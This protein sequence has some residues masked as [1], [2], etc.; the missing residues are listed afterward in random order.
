MSW[1]QAA[2]EGNI[3]ALNATINACNNDVGTL[4]EAHTGLTPLHYAAKCGRLD[5]V[6]FLLDKHLALNATDRFGRTPLYMG[7]LHQQPDTVGFLLQKKANPNICCQ[8][9]TTALS[10]AAEYGDKKM[11]SLLLDAGA[12]WNTKNVDGESPKELAARNGHGMPWERHEAAQ[13][14]RLVD[15]A[16][17]GD[18]EDMKR[19]IQL[20]VE[21]AD[22]PPKSM[23]ALEAACENGRIDVVR[24][25]LFDPSVSRA[26]ASARI[27]SMGRLA[28]HEA[29]K[30]GYDEVVDLLLGTGLSSDYRDPDNMTPLHRA[31]A[32][33]HEGVAEVLLKFHAD[34]NAKGVND[35]SPLHQAAMQG[36]AEMVQF[37]LNKKANPAAKDGQGRTAKDVARRGALRVFEDRGL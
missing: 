30:K 26:P 28:V 23:S 11:L 31:A 25:L 33:G 18:V 35:A 9:K 27:E 4:V 15:A 6:Q 36:R 34:I 7:I 16:A 14:E 21:P 1:K 8:C 29:A 24:F 12:A 20:G 3:A 37:L 5:A 13:R 19:L 17:R 22:R 2:E 32:R 10:K